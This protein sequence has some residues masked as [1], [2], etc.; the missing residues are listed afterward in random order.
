[1]PLEWNNFLLLAD[2]T[3]QVVFVDPLS[4]RRKRG[5]FIGRFRF[6][7]VAFWA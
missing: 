6:G 2:T 5:G 4:A 1:M 7:V 3:A